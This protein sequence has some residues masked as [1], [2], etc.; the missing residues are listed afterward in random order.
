MAEQTGGS[1]L[2]VGW[3]FWLA[4][5][6]AS[7]VGWAAGAAIAAVYS[8]P[9]IIVGGYVRLALGGILFGGFQSL[10][11]RG[12]SRRAM[13]WSCCLRSSST[14]SRCISV[15]HLRTRPEWYGESSQ[16][17]HSGVYGPTMFN[18]MKWSRSL[19]TIRSQTTPRS[20]NAGVTTVRGNAA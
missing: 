15:K 7:T 4:W 1:P 5:V 16:S 2:A 19:P 10:V 20:L 11:L 6:A 12:Q 8:Y 3:G 13:S 14:G 18:W 17:A 9:D